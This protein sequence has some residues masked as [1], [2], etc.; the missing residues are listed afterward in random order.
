[1]QLSLLPLSLPDTPGYQVAASLQ[2]ATEVGGDFY[3][4]FQIDENR[5]LFTIG[6]VSGKGSSAALYMAQ[7]M[8]LIRYSRQFTDDPLEIAG[9]LNAFFATSMVDRQIFVTA[10]IGILDITKHRVNYI[11]AGHNLPV[12]LPGAKSKKIHPVKSPGLGIG[13]TA[14]QEVFAKSLKPVELQMKS[15][16]SLFFYTDGVIEASKPL[17]KMISTDL[18][19]DVYEEERLETLLNDAR[20]KSP[21]EIKREIELDLQS[22]YA[23]HSRVD[24]HTL[25]II[26]RERPVKKKPAAK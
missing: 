6:D 3:D 24:D 11:R 25:L 19:R 22:F 5:F 12:F 18:E 20:D 15:W 13:L 17:P 14:R 26:Q 7:C 1:M 9:R 4:M 10:I 2:T 21:A 8:S 23:G 16:D